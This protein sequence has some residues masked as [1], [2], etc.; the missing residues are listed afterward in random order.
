VLAPLDVRAG[1]GPVQALLRRARP[2]LVRTEESVQDLPGARE[3][4]LRAALLLFT[5]GSSGAPKGVVLSRDGLRANVEAI[6]GYLPAGRA[7]IVLPLTYSYALVGQLLTTLRSGAA[8]LLLGDLKY[9]AEQLEAMR[10]LEADALSTVPSSLRLL[11]LAIAEGSPAPRLRTVASAGAPFDAGTIALVRSAFPGARIW[12]QYGL[13]EASPRVAAISDADPSFGRGAAGRALP[14]I[15][16]R[17]EGGEILVRGPSVMLG[18]LD[19]PEATAAALTPDGWLRTGDLGRIEDGCLFSH[20]RGDGVV[21]CAGER[22]GLEE[23]A[24]A[25][26][27]CDGV[28]DACVVAIPDQALGAKLIAFLE[29]ARPEIVPAVRKALRET[30]TPAKRPAMLVAL[31]A[32][33]RMAS[34]KIDRQA[35]QRRAELLS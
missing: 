5:S 9:P 14:G 25:L 4:D 28:G 29:T 2:S 27:A 33:P 24:A 11:S 17:T 31:E 13:T 21:K 7:A 3:L 19:D 15:E 10:R 23:V 1:H 8:A 30:L 12:N 16:I 6:L 34:G 32:L 18:Y 20:G 26:R 22:V 35:L